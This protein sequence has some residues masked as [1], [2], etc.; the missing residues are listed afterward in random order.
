MAWSPNW[1]YRQPPIGG[2]RA[3]SSNLFRTSRIGATQGKAK[4]H[5]PWEPGGGA[6]I[7]L[8]KTEVGN[9]L[10]SATVK[11][12]RISKKKATKK[13]KKKKKKKK[14]KKGISSTVPP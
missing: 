3:G 6:Q 7:V 4:K 10:K 12:K 8:K 1:P 13:K 14:E 2:E 9:N 5:K 11:G